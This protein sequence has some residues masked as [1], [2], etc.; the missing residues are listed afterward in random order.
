MAV[1]VALRQQQQQQQQR[2]LLLLLLL[3]LLAVHDNNN[4]ATILLNNSSR[5]IG[6]NRGKNS[7]DRAPCIGEGEC[8]P[9]HQEVQQ[10]QARRPPT[11]RGSLQPQQEQEQGCLSLP[12]C[13]QP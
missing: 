6:N 3:L 9:A 12:S 8:R 10:Q 1:V 5:A 4:Q 13:L 11:H 7:R 2:L